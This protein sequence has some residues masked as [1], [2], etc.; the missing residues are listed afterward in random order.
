VVTAV[1]TVG[2]DGEDIIERPT[3]GGNLPD[4]SNFGVLAATETAF[5]DG[6]GLQPI[7]SFG[8]TDVTRADMYDNSGNELAYSR[9]NASDGSSFNTTRTAND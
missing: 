5:A 7:G 8:T 6:S 9:Y 4:L 1:G 2:Y 3:V